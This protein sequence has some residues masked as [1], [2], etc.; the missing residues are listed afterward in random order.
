MSRRNALDVALDQPG[1]PRMA[2]H[3]F[4]LFE[5]SEWFALCGQLTKRRVYEIEKLD[6]ICDDISLRPDVAQDIL[7]LISAQKDTKIGKH[8]VSAAGGLIPPLPVRDAVWLNAN[9]VGRAIFKLAR[10]KKHVV[11]H[12]LS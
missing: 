3:K 1:Y 2:P 4:D 12:A 11:R 6:S 7:G 5:A 9:E 10:H 8:F